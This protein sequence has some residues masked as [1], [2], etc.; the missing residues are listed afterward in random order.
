MIKIGPITLH[1][2]IVQGSY[3]WHM[4]RA[5]SLGSSDFATAAGAGKK[6]RK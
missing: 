4:M 1:D 6:E 2:D 5:V 3:E